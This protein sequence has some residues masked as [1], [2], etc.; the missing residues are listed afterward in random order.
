MPSPLGQ[1]CAR[2]E[3]LQKEVVLSRLRFVRTNGMIKAFAIFLECITRIYLF[4][5]FLFFITTR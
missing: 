5:S 4:R 2:F 3:S 1:Y